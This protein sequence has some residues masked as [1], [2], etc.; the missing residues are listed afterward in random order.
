MAWFFFFHLRA[1]VRRQRV[2]SLGPHGHDV[3]G[4]PEVH[5]ARSL[6]L[7]L[8]SQDHMCSLVAGTGRR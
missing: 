4:Q 7:G 6:V 8:V 5:E 2:V 3:P 1:A